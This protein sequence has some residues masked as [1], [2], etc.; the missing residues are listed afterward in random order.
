MRSKLEKSKI[1][2]CRSKP[3]STWKWKS[4]TT[5]VVILTNGGISTSNFSLRQGPS[6]RPTLNICN[7]NTSILCLSPLH[8]C[9]GSRLLR[10]WLL[11]LCPGSS[12]KY[13]GQK[14]ERQKS[15]KVAA[16]LSVFLFPNQGQHK[17]IEQIE[18]PSKDWC[19]LKLIVPLL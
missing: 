6:P 18:R 3:L 10:D 1:W 11:P 19:K 8:Q 15:I 7:P 13:I 14:L 2:A 5:G 4:Y 9:D 12:W 17:S 16:H